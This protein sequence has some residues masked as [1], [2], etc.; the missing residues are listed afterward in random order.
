MKKILLFLYALAITTSVIPRGYATAEIGLEPQP[1]LVVNSVSNTRI[2][3]KF[4]DGLAWFVDA[5]NKYGYIDI[6]GNIVIEAQYT[7]ACDFY[8]GRAVVS[9]SQDGAL[10]D[11]VIDTKGNQII[12]NLD[13]STQIIG[14]SH[15]MAED[16]PVVVINKATKANGKYTGMKSE[17]LNYLTDY[18]TLLTTEKYMY[19]GAFSEG[20][21]LVGTGNKPADCS[22]CSSDMNY[23]SFEAFKGN[24]IQRAANTFYYIDRNGNK[25]GN[26]TWDYGG[27]FS[28]GYAAV[29]K[30]NAKGDL[31]W[32][33][34]NTKGELAIDIQFSVA[35]EFND[36]RAVVKKGGKAFYIDTTGENTMQQEFERVNEFKNGYASVEIN[37]KW[38]VLDENANLVIPCLYTYITVFPE[39]GIAVVQEEKIDDH[40]Y[41]GVVSFDGQ[42]ILPTIYQAIDV[43]A[44]RLIV[45]QNDQ[46]SVMNL[47]GETIATM[48]PGVAISTYLCNDYLLRIMKDGKYGYIDKEGNIIRTLEL[49]EGTPWYERYPEFSS[50]V[51]I[52]KKN[53][54]WFIMDDKG[55]ILF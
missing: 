38:G 6:Y 13:T 5:N 28:E 44:D 20:Y 3:K 46:Y 18:G 42:Q 50:G 22:L 23:V 7:G 14:Y 11:I 48:E 45:N 9:Y 34:I 26:S 31:S 21:A 12:G 35:G 51:A 2:A 49:D 8:N 16:M 27:K 17:G 25:L 41:Y 40:Y 15:Y 32:G 19:A 43:F 30:R 4:V 39:N 52:V 24:T 36:G 47:Q 33:Y 10:H 29:A 37:G 55:V 1:P 54:S 53:G